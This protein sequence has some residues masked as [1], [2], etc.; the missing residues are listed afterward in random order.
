M[1]WSV[2]DEE[3]PVYSS[4]ALRARPLGSLAASLM[5]VAAIAVLVGALAVARFSQGEPAPSQAAAE[6]APPVAAK[7]AA[8]K[9]VATR[10]DIFA[11]PQSGSGAI[12]RQAAGFDLDVAELAKEKKVSASPPPQSGGRRETLSLGE[13]ES[14]KLYL[15]LD[16]LQPA[17]E[18]L[19][20]SDFFLDMTRHAAQ[21]GLAVSRIGQPTPLA[22]R[23]GAFESADIRL[24]QNGGGSA[25]LAA[26]ERG[27]L[28][29]RLINS[30]LSI[31][32][33]G[34]AC[35]AGARPIDRRTMSCLL[36]RLYY[37]PGGD[38]KALERAFAKA[39]PDR[40][41]GCFAPAAPADAEAGARPAPKKRAAA[42]RH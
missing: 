9:S 15:R 42:P 18:K 2:S 24:S 21:A 16:I 27:C 13:F 34:L 23:V 8:A 5:G 26:G 30:K 29:V 7:T 33:A 4:G 19:G 40:G 37:L 31:E 20:N 14:G 22:S 17:G 1:S 10:T 41:Q 32:I 11:P 6:S 38:D 25:P 39:D 3:F 36:D 28:A 35:G 12:A